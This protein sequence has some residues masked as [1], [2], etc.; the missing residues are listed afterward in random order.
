VKAFSTYNYTPLL[1]LQRTDFINLKSTQTIYIPFGDD[2]LLPSQLTQLSREVPV[3][4]AIINCKTNYVVGKGLTSD[5]PVLRELI[6]NPNNTYE[7]FNTIFRRLV[8]DYILIGNAYLEIITNEKHS[9][10]YY[11][12]VDSSKC[13]LSSV[14]NEVLIHPSWEEFKGKGD[15]NM[16]NV[17]LFPDFAKG[18]DGLLHSI[19]HIKDYEPEFYYYGLCSYFAAMRPILISGLTNLW[20][21]NR[22]ERGFT[23]PGLLVVGGINDVSDA[24][25]LDAELGK[26]N[27]VDGEKS[28]N[29]VIQYLAD[30]SPGQ[31]TQEAKFVEFKKNEEGNWTN[32]HDQS[33]LSII[34]M[35]NWFRS[36]TPYAN[37]KSGFDSNRIINEYEI[38]LSTVIH[39]LQEFFARHFDQVFTYFKIPVGKLGFINEPPIQRI[40]PLKFVW[41]ARQD[42]GLPFDKTDPVQNQLI[43]QLK[44]SF[45]QS[46]QSS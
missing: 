13:R 17:P 28:G 19:Y 1:N 22:L 16:T 38:A 30:L 43:L 39:P 25:E 35:H 36:L 34:T 33:E 2:N 31:S 4:R 46:V 41:E 11:Y 42:A 5:N 24:E 26:F 10:V 20:N 27:G 44:N 23:S 37:E 7:D 40:N 18:A 15:P 21:Q 3:H 45:N 12:H 32:L 14:T 6:K 9:F 29:M 8:F